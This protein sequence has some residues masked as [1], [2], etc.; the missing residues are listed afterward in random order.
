MSSKEFEE[1]TLSN[2]LKVAHEYDF[3]SYLKIGSFF[4][5]HLH[6]GEVI[7]SFLWIT[8]IESC[9]SIEFEYVNKND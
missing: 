7:C 6:R 9:K 2:R 4:E 8:H 1:E 3:K 5:L